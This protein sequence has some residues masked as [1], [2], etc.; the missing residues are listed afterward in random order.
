MAR[1]TK[2]KKGEDTNDYQKW[3]REY[4]Y[5]SCSHI[6]TDPAVIKSIIGEH[7]KQLYAHNLTIYKG[8]NSQKTQPTKTQ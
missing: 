3:K 8:P 5:R 1:L 6:T 2:I 4:H 7:Y